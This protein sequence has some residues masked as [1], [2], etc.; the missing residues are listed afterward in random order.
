M[1]KGSRARR[2]HGLW[3]LRTAQRWASAVLLLSVGCAQLPS[4]NA[5]AVAPIPVGEA[6]LW[7]YRNDGPYDAQTTPYVRLNG[8]V[9][10]VSEAD[11][12]FYRDVAPGH[13]SITIDSPATD[14]NQFADANLAAGQQTYAKIL[15][16][17][18]WQGG[19]MAEPCR[20][21]FYVRLMAA[22]T[23]RT[24]IAHSPFYGGS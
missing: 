15:S 6:R 4:T 9:V 16:L 5:V 2:P 17:R 24:E 8:Q 20:D 21:A 14:V 22:E 7:I 23:A 1:M 11:G 12:A 13:Y 10:G 19:A 18:C 3:N